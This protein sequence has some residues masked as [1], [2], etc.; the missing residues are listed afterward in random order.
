MTVTYDASSFQFFF[1]ALWVT[2]VGLVVG[3]GYLH[4]AF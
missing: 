1:V 3:L 2:K 4:L